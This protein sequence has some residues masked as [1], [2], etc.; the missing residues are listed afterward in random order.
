MKR[1]SIDNG[2]NYIDPREAVESISWETIVNY[3]DDE[4]REAVHNEHI[5]NEI[6]YLTRYL[7]IAPSDLI[8]G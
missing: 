5:D 7:E 2:H 4:T 1:I 6:E 3:M 8:I